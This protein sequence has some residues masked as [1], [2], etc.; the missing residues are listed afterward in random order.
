MPSAWVIMS[1][2][3][4]IISFI[5][6][7]GFYYLIS[8]LSSSTKK[9][10]L[11]Q[12]LSYSMNFVIYIWVG[13]VFVNIQAFINDPLAVLAYPSNSVALY[14]GICLLAVNVLYNVWKKDFDV[15]WWLQAFAPVLLATSFTYE[16]IQLIQKE[17]TYGLSYLVLLMA[18]LIVFILFQERLRSSILPSLLLAAW[19]AGLCALS[20]VLP[21][22]TIF[23]YTIH[24]WFSL[25]L[26]IAFVCLGYY[27]YR[28]QVS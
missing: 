28:K 5:V 25:V 8:P 13:K 10:Q 17:S 6:G 7:I 4:I 27:I 21:Y 12:V 20:F 24:T 2:G 1:V 16:F 15:N 14:I 18:L 19:A 9:E 22:I 26:F 3:I 11:E 23:G